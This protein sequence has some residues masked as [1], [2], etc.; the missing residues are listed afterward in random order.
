[1]D[2]WAA[3]NDSEKYP[4]DDLTW[5]KFDHV[6]KLFGPRIWNLKKF[7]ISIMTVQ[8]QEESLLKPKKKGGISYEDFV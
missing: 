1:M 7:Y 6:I 5:D 3:I 2:F 4:C 8:I